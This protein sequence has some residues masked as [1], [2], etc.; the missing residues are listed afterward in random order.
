[1]PL[2]YLLFWF[3]L[4]SS[5]WRLLLSLCSAC[6]NLCHGSFLPHLPLFFFAFYRAKAENAFST[7]SARFSKEIHLWSKGCSSGA[8]ALCFSFVFILPSSELFLRLSLPRISIKHLSSA[9]HWLFS[10]SARHQWD[11]WL[12]F[13]CLFLVSVSQQ[14]FA[15]WKWGSGENWFFLL[16]CINLLEKTPLPVT[17]EWNNSWAGSFPLPLG[18]HSLLSSLLSHWLGPHSAG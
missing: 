15:C 8:T 14:I 17:V 18:I 3:C 5:S 12:F 16:L 9:S 13:L 11:S 2:S 6:V 10:A 7:S 4:S 1:M